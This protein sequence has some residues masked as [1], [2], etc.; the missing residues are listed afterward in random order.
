MLFFESY[1]SS[2]IKS[3]KISLIDQFKNE[4]LHCEFSSFYE[5]LFIEPSTAQSLKRRKC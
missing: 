5:L 4:M 3:L 2:I 1:K